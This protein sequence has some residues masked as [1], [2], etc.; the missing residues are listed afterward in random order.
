MYGNL[1]VHLTFS[2]ETVFELIGV[3]VVA[4]VLARSWLWA[5]HAPALAAHSGGGWPR[6][7][8]WLELEVLLPEFEELLPQPARTTVT[9]SAARTASAIAPRRPVRILF[10]KDIV[11]RLPSN[12]GTYRNGR[13]AAPPRLHGQPPFALPTA[14]N[15]DY[16]LST[17]QQQPSVPLVST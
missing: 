12:S 4:R 3:W 16:L 11:E 1:K 10:A 9:V 5:G 17:R 6:A 15:P 7:A 8:A 2:F 13:R 14:P